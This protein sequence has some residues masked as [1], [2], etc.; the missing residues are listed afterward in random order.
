MN[1]TRVPVSDKENILSG[2]LDV[3]F[4]WEVSQWFPLIFSVSPCRGVLA[5]EGLDGNSGSDS[6]GPFHYV[7]LNEK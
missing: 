2:K 1:V 6:V 5:V 7:K 3:F 4:S